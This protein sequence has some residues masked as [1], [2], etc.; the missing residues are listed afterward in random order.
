MMIDM[1]LNPDEVAILDDGGYLSLTFPE[2]FL[3]TV[4]KPGHIFRKEVDDKWDEPKEEK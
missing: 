4:S 2:G 1:Q 3:I